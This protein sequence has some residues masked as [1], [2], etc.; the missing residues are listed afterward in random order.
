[1]ELGDQRILVTGAS[2]S[3]GKQLLY[4]LCQRSIRPIAH[5]RETSD[6][7]YIDSLGLAKR[8]ADL[9]RRDDLPKLV[10]GIDAIIHTAAWVNFRGDRMTQFTD[11]NVFAAVD[12]FR[13]AQK[14]GVKRFVQVSSVA[15][16]GAVP[17]KLGGRSAHLF[18]DETTEFNLE[19]LRIPYVMT[20][21][22]AEEELR[23]L[24]QGGRTELVIV[25]P[26]IVM[27]PSR[28]GDD[29]S[30]ALKAFGKFF[31][32]QF[33]NRVNL[34]D[35]RDVGPGILAALEKGRPGE[36]YILG[37]DNITV[38]ELVLAISVALG[39]EPH[40]GALP[41]PMLEF[42]ARVS[43]TFHRVFGKAKLTFYPDLVKL[44]DYDWAY[45]SRKARQEL[46]YTNRSIHISLHELFTNSF[47][48]TYLKP[49]SAR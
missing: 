44:L 25:N 8:C 7:T 22:A 31:M 26:S 48:G 2:G 3:L 15:A 12:L 13:Q 39:R 40:V 32:P 43:R 6:T 47:T 33:P 10:D 27:A 45:S 34:V 37:G 35:I 21:H 46:G 36:R 4:E 16:I 30:K 5:V 24:A 38:K 41:R 1:M 14:A 19:R 28:T 18:A 11:I 23:K 17:R 49:R 29:R 20:K 9:G 42:A